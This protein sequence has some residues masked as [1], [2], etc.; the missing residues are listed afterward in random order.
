MKKKKRSAKKKKQP[1]KK[2]TSPNVQEYEKK[3]QREKLKT[4]LQRRPLGMAGTNQMALKTVVKRSSKCC[5]Q[6]ITQEREKMKDTLRCNRHRDRHI[7]T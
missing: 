2:K 6:L 5:G 1:A 3:R 4:N 7:R